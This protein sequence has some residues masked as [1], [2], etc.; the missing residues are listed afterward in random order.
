[1]IKT[2]TNK[3]I[4]MGML[5]DLLDVKTAVEKTDDE[6]EQDND[7]Y[8]NVSDDLDILENDLLVNY[9]RLDV[10][11]YIKLRQ[12]DMLKKIVDKLDDLEMLYDVYNQLKALNNKQ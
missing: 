9:K 8:S 2:Q 3:E 5:M 1:M 11:S 12:L 6:F 4:T 10:D 7:K